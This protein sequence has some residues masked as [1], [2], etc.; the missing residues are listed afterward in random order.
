[1]IP[2]GDIRASRVVRVLLWFA[3]LGAGAYLANERDQN[4]S[5]ARGYASD[6]EIYFHA[7]RLIV[8]GHSPYTFSQ[9]VYP[10]FI[11]LLLA[12]FT[13]F[14]QASVFDVWQAISVTAVAVAVVGTVATVVSDLGPIQK[15]I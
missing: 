13:S 3:A 15:P 5:H 2:R 14:R 12:P 8:S 7:A 10:P 9:Y 11:A 4:F 1:M 6:F